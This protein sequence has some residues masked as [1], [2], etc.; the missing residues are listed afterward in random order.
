MKNFELDKK[1]LSVLSSTPFQAVFIF[2]FLYSVCKTN[3]R[4]SF[5]SLQRERNC[6]GGMQLI[7]AQ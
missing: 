7:T 2:W 4:K 6:A 3:N 1:L 5:L